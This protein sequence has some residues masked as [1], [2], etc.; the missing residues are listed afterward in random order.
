MSATFYVLS[1]LEPKEMIAVE[2]AAISAVE[3]YLAEHPD[4]ED[5]WGEMSAG[6]YLPTEEEARA[7][8]A[9]YR[10]PLDASVLAR[11]ARCRSCFTID[12]PGDIDGVDDLQVSLLRFVLERT[13]EGLVLLNDYPFETSEALLAKLKRRPQAKGFAAIVEPAKASP[14]RPVARRHAKAGELRAVRVLRTLEAALN[15]VRVSIDVKEALRRVSEGAR[16]Y[17]ALLLEEGALS[18]AK[19]AAA[20]RVPEAEVARAAEELESAL[21]RR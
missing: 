9:K 15:D 4:C 6:G 18:D 11:L 19:A 14:R 7:A 1:P 20:L 16:N 10:L 17:G 21:A 8:Y 13:G 5:E 3:T 2:Q 12:R